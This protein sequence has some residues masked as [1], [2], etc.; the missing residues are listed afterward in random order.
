MTHCLAHRLE[1]SFKDVTKTISG[2]L[3]DKTMTLLLGLYYHYHKSPKQ[4]KQL[5]LAFEI[6]DRQMVTPTRV[7]G[8]RWLPHM[9]RAIK[10]LLKGYR[11]FR[12]QLEQ[13]SHENP[14]AEGL[15]KLMSDINVMAFILTL[16][17]VINPLVR[18]SKFLQ[19]N[20]CILADGMSR[21]VATQEL[22]CSK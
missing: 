18:L 5:E 8:T 3:Y 11:A 22:P 10:V 6:N 15:A 13:S 17:E 4:K 9:D 16:R 20:E 14:K 2:R 12:Y 7:G 1:L 21:V 19:R